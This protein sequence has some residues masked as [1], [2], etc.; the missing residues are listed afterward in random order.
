[1]LA[2]YALLAS[3]CLLTSSMGVAPLDSVSGIDS[4]SRITQS[5]NTGFLTGVLG[6]C[7]D[8]SSYSNF[9]CLDAVGVPA[10]YGS[11]ATSLLIP[12]MR[13]ID[14]QV[15]YTERSIQRCERTLSLETTI[16]T[17][18]F[19]KGKVSCNKTTDTCTI[20]RAVLMEAAVTPVLRSSSSCQPV[21][22]GSI[23]SFYDLNF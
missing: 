19:L 16:L 12:Q 6:F 15:F 2:M 1:M 22:T 3:G 21:P 4:R 20:D 17:D 7:A 14:S 11:L 23:I 9:N 8:L 5:V 13:R 10:F 18:Q